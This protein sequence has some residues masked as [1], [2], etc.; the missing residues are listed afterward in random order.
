MSSN[1]LDAAKT[2]EERKALRAHLQAGLRDPFREVLADFLENAPTPAAIQRLAE[3]QPDRHA[4]GAA[5]WGRLAGYADQT[6][7]RGSLTVHHIHTLSDAELDAQ[8]AAIDAAR[9]TVI[10]L[11]NPTQPVRAKRRRTSARALKASVSPVTRQP[12]DSR[13]ASGNDAG[14]SEVSGQ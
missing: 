6:E 12:G 14:S 13:S 7:S 8:I 2:P 11:T 10:D 1:P 9:R 3:Q 5:I 4:T